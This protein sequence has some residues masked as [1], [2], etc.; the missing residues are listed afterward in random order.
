MQTHYIESIDATDKSQAFRTL[1]FIVSN[2]A[3]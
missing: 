3:R 1:L 2:K